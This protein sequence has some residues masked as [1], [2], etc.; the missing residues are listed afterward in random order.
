MGGVGWCV[1]SPSEGATPVPQFDETIRVVVQY[2]DL[3]SCGSQ[4]GKV[5]I[6][7]CIHIHFDF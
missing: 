2:I 6:K 5:N 7:I 1:T 4:L 3:D